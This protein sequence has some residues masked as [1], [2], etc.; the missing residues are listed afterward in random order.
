MLLPGQGVSGGRS[1]ILIRSEP[2]E[3]PEPLELEDS[4]SLPMPLSVPNPLSEGGMLVGSAGRATGRVEGPEGAIEGFAV[5]GAIGLVAGRVVT[6]GFE[7]V[8]RFGVAEGR[9]AADRL[10]ADALGRALLEAEDPERRVAERFPSTLPARVA[11]EDFRVVLRLGLADLDLGLLAARFA[12]VFPARF[13]VTRLREE[14]VF[15]A[16]GR[17]AVDFLV[18]DFFFAGMSPP[19]D[20]DEPSPVGFSADDEVRCFLRVIASASRKDKQSVRL[21]PVQHGRVDLFTLEVDRDGVSR[22][23]EPG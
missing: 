19:S 12:S 13:A 15:F 7:A 3:P 22:A 18:G 9:F 2:P 14:L 11:V 23:F 16:V 4:D 1:P 10:L 6:A 21:Q 20:G 17:F 8:A 5:G